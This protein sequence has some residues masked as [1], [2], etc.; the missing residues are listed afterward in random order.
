MTCP[1]DRDRSLL[2]FPCP[3]GT[4]LVQAACLSHWEKHNLFH[5]DRHSSCPTFACPSG[6]GLV[7][8]LPFQSWHLTKFKVVPYQTT[9]GVLIEFQKFL[10]KNLKLSIIETKIRFFFTNLTKPSAW[11]ISAI[12]RWHERSIC[13]CVGDWGWQD[14]F[15]HGANFHSTDQASQGISGGPSWDG[16]SSGSERWFEAAASFCR[17]Y[18][19]HFAAAER[20]FAA[21]ASFCSQ[22]RCQFRCFCSWWR[23][24]FCSR[25]SEQCSCSVS[26]CCQVSKSPESGGVGLNISPLFLKQME[27][28]TKREAVPLGHEQYIENSPSG[29]LHQHA[30]HP[31]AAVWKTVKQLRDVTLMGK[32]F[33][34][35][36]DRAVYQFTHVCVRYW[37]LLK[38]TFDKTRQMWKTNE[39]LHHLKVEHGKDKHTLTQTSYYSRSLSVRDKRGG[40]GGNGRWSWRWCRQCGGGGCRN[41]G[42]WWGGGR[43]V[44]QYRK[45]EWGGASS[46]SR[47][48]S[49]FSVCD[50]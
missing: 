6:T 12:T 29:K 30:P 26:W 46:G 34:D 40:E 19:C 33:S 41:G 10:I 44:R 18:F 25:S 42:V 43:K 27:D 21:T 35:D 3:S 11:S 7:Q 31:P 16:W 37:K 5:W 9:K 24:Q 20:C 50:S 14:G 36:D 13:A 38:M 45:R 23:C 15:Q 47:G 32:R 4:D 39:L 17:C 8:V 1:W 48:T 22:W 49:P 2:T 28:E